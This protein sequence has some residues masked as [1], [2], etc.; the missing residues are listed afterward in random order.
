V[1]GLGEVVVW[2]QPDLVE[3]ETRLS[4]RQSVIALNRM[5]SRHARVRPPHTLRHLTLPLLLY[6][7]IYFADAERMRVI[8]FA[9]TAPVLNS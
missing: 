2:G 7:R 8:N 6:P 3:P 9:S 1:G 4:Q 5:P